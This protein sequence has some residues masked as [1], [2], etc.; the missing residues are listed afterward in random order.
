MPPSLK[1]RSAR[2][3]RDDHDAFTTRSRTTK[4]SSLLLLLVLSSFQ[5]KRPNDWPLYTLMSSAVKDINITTTS[6]SY[7]VSESYY[8]NP[9]PSLSAI[10]RTSWNYQQA[11]AT[12]ITAF[13]PLGS[14]IRH[15]PEEYQDYMTK[16]FSNYD[17]M[18]IFTSPEFEP[19]IRAMRQQKL[20]LSLIVTMYLNETKS[21]KMFPEHFWYNDVFQPSRRIR[22]LGSNKGIVDHLPYVVWNSKVEFL[23]IGS[24]K[25]PFQSNFFAWTDVGMVRWDQY[26]NTTLLQRIPS[27]LPNNKLLIMDV[28][29]VLSHKKYKQMSAGMFAGH[30]TAI[31]LY[32][33]KYYQVM[34]AAGNSKDAPLLSTE[35]F[36]LHRTC[37]QSPGLCHIIV[38]MESNT[39]GP[40]LKFPYFYML[41][42]F[43]ANQY[44][45]MQLN[46][47]IHPCNGMQSLKLQDECVATAAANKS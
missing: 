12:L 4:W 9:S 41:A 46:G 8:Q 7:E 6:G 28:T 2:S 21:W 18:I 24:D 44:K 35:Q 31:D 19:N 5:M 32:Y 37:L 3:A 1:V 27:E 14:S 47:K 43:N 15:T 20:E 40:A 45:M 42:M 30:K 25:N 17:A 39:L 34:E 33:K 13:F 36:L 26:A 10:T 11:D 22:S 29:P 23:K 38:P 16:L